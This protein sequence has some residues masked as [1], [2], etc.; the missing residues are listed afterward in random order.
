MRATASEIRSLSPQFPQESEIQADLNTALGLG[1]NNFGPGADPDE[2]TFQFWRRAVIA[3][4]AGSVMW[5][6]IR[7]AVSALLALSIPR[8]ARLTSLTGQPRSNLEA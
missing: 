1:G 5:I 3:A 7:F 2:K 6:G 8:V 4:V